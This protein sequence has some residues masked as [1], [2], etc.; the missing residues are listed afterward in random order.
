MT[1]AASAI[2]ERVIRER[3]YF[4]ATKIVDLKRFGFGEV[5]CQVPAL[6]IPIFG[7]DGQIVLYQ[8]R[9]DVPR[10][11]PEKASLS[12]MRRR[13][14]HRW[15]LMCPHR[16]VATF[17]DPTTP[18]LITEGVKKA[19]SAVSNGFDC[20]I[21]LL[22]VWNWR[23]VNDDGGKTA[24][25]EFEYIAFNDRTSLLVFDSDVMT[26]CAVYAALRRFA[27]FLAYRGAK[28]RFVY[29]PA[30]PGGTKVG[31][32]DFFAAGHTAAEVR[33]LATDEL[34]APPDDDDHA[35]GP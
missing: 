27:G 9:P 7:P 12:N 18:L 19:D 1:H 22:G 13:A 23:G 5:Q 32:D 10:I 4:S 20:A 21:A 2:A 6:G 30:E 28:V 3:G 29:L 35:A 8:S 15:R 26:K 14:R 33:D 17:G 25:A 31:L 34:R 16:L 11:G 24:L